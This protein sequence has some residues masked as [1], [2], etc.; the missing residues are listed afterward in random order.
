MLPGTLY[1][2]VAPSQHFSEIPRAGM[3]FERTGLMDT[4]E[5]AGAVLTQFVLPGDGARVM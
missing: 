5:M 2:I 4:L 3:M 1:R